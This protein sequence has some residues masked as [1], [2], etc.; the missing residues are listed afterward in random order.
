M[1][2]LTEERKEL[3]DQLP[4]KELLR[5]W[6]FTPIGDPIFQGPSG[7]YLKDRLLEARS[8]DPAEFTRASKE[9]GF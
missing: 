8:A 6:R 4:L 2:E 9:I 7:E 3:I 5:M 1:A